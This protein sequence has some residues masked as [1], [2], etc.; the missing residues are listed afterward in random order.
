METEMISSYTDCMCGAHGDEREKMD[1]CLK[2]QHPHVCLYK[3]A[4]YEKCDDV[5]PAM[6]VEMADDK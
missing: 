1:E 3:S 4:W 2:T 5:V 6:Q